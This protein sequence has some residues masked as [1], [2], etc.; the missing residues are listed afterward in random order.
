MSTKFNFL[1]LDTRIR[2]L[3]KEEIKLADLTNNL[4]YSSRFNESGKATWLGLLNTAAALHDEHW[5][6]YQLEI[7]R[8]MKDYEDKEKLNG[9]YTIAHVP[10]TAAETFADGQFNRIYI[11]AICR[12]AIEQ[13]EREVAVYRAKTRIGSRQESDALEGTKKDAASLLKMVQDTKSSFGCDLLKPNS[14]LSVK[15]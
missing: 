12:Y 14:G 3:M 7:N 4:Y 8:A 2:E 1:Q 15:Y 11:A 13:G 10:H 6:A 9:G 5:L